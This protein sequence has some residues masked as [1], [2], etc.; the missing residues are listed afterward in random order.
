M[1]L[2][3]CWPSA[4]SGSPDALFCAPVVLTKYAISCPRL[5]FG[6]VSSA[7]SMR[8]GLQ[9]QRAAT[10]SAGP[11]F[12]SHNTGKNFKRKQKKSK[13]HETL[14]LGPCYTSRRKSLQEELSEDLLSTQLEAWACGDDWGCLWADHLWCVCRQTSWCTTCFPRLNLASFR[15]NCLDE[16]GQKP[17]QLSV[18]HTGLQSKSKNRT[19]STQTV[20]PWGRP[21]R[22]APTL[23]LLDALTESFCKRCTLPT[24]DRAVGHSTNLLERHV[25][26]PGVSSCATR[27]LC[28]VTAHPWLTGCLLR[29]TRTRNLLGDTVAIA[30]LCA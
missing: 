11:L 20:A 25:L 22:P 23:N 2:I 21:L 13:E 18:P 27:N 3:H 30:I 6:I 9:P 26:R 14:E 5:V 16:L 15:M 24:Q 17:V 7:A 4:L 29:T 19:L 12:P 8:C 28:V 1:R 10:R